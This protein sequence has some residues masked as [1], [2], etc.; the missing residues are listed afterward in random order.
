MAQR[1]RLSAPRFEPQQE[2]SWHQVK[3]T[4][5]SVNNF[6]SGDRR[7]EAE[8]YLSSGYGLRLAIESRPVGWQPL[9]EY[10]NVWQPSRLKGIQVSP[11]FGTPFLAATQMFDI[12]PVPRKWLAVERTHD[13]AN[14]F[15]NAGTIVVTCSGA[16]G[17]A[18]L[19]HAPHERTLISHDLLR[20]EMRDQS[21]WGWIYAYLRSPQARA[22]MTSAQY[23]H[24]IKHLETSHLNALPVPVLNGERAREFNALTAEILDLR[25]RAYSRAVDAD[26]LYSKALGIIH[27]A[28]ENSFSVH[29]SA[30][31]TGRRRLEANYHAPLPTAI[32]ER[33]QEIDTRVEPLA[34]VTDGVW[35]MNRF[36]RF[37]GDDGIPYLSADELFSINPLESKR[38]LVDPNDN[39][40]DYFVRAGWIVMACSGQVYGLNGAALLMTEHHEDIFF[41]H[42]LIRIIPN[43]EKIRPG[44]LLVTL[45]HSDLGRPL[46]IRAAYGTSI[47]HLDPNDV[48]AFPVVRLSTEEETAIADLAEESA[49]FRAQADEKERALSTAAGDLIDR[50]VAGDKE[51]FV[52]RILP[53]L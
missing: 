7:M 3:W 25:N 17:R 40:A 41:S 31:F 51:N 44:Y 20:V 16:V 46:L 8:N 39:H 30:F 14:R 52:T 11:D 32:L 47:P 43:T 36:K 21:Q 24:I 35:W 15:I 29:A 28:A 53:R 26:E 33:F 10:A 49:G 34:S 13:A 27:P 37:Y 38:I 4:S 22:M 50:F 45:T 42:D 9:A 2:W 18:T 19:A 12:R 5:L 1:A 48:A 23:G 6:R